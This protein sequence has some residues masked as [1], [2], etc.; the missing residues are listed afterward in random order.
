MNLDV[1]TVREQEILESVIHYFVITGNPAGSRT[2]SRKN[3]TELSAATVRNVM[4]DLEEKGY[5]DHPHTSAGRVPTTKGYRHYVDNLIQLSQLSLQE[6]VLIKENLGRFDGD[7]DYILGKTAQIMA[8]ISHQ[9]GVIL[10]PKLE[11]GILE[12]IDV[13]PVSSDKIL[14]ILLE[15]KN[16]I[17][18]HMLT[19]IV[20]ILNERICGLK[21]NEIRKT[22]QN[23]LRDLMDEET[24]L[25]RLFIDSAGNLFDFSRYSDIK[26]TGASNI[27]TNPEFSDIS[28]FS[29]LVELLEEK[30][31]IIHIMEKRSEPP[32]L[33]V[34]IGDENE[35]AL[36]RECSIISAPYTFGN[37]DGVVGVI[38]PTR[39][40]YKR[41]IPLVDFTAKWI[42]RMFREK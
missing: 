42:T 35:E 9:L 26:Y 17:S 3:K 15:V 7:V 14:L 22:F 4:A 38:G 37:V 10:T 33:K 32:G 5:L 28:K 40:A 16:E 11:E 13:V 24:G 39:M 34:T 36:I 41:I 8:R 31:I 20:Q 2:I 23:R 1:L 29:A 30:N 6:Q 25:I 18:T 21:I 12:K 27:S 19:G